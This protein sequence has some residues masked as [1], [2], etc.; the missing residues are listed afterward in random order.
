MAR[1]PKRQRT[2]SWQPLE[3]ADLAE[4]EK[5]RARYL[6]AGLDPDKEL[7]REVWRND[8]YTVALR[9]DT[10]D[11]RDG[12]VQIS[13]HRHDRAAVRDWRHGQ[14]IKNETMGPLRWAVELY[15]SERDL[16][17]TSNEYHL[18]VMP[19]GT[20]MP[21]GSHGAAVAEPQ[22][23]RAADERAGVGRSRA[24]QRPWQPGLTTGQHGQLEATRAAWAARLT[25]PTEGD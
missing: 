4:P 12:L 15:P 7:P 16:M 2:R 8:L 11:G 24:R 9:W 18:W 25:P 13:Y 19:V 5:A 3:P 10:E 1:R 14:Q 20:P 21:F 6:A 23:L 17:D 22:D